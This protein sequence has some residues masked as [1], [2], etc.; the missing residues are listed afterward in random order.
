MKKTISLLLVC[1]FMTML[2]IPASGNNGDNPNLHYT[3]SL[4]ES[5]SLEDYTIYLEDFN[6]VNFNSSQDVINF[7]YTTG[8]NRNN[9][10]SGGTGVSFYTLSEEEKQLLIDYWYYACQTAA[11]SAAAKIVEMALYPDTYETDGALSNAF[12]H[13]YWTMMLCKYTSP[14][15]AIAFVT[16]HENR[17]NN[18]E[19]QKNMDLH[20]NQVSY[21][22]YVN[23]ISSSYYSDVELASIVQ[24]KINN[25]DYIY[26][27]Y[28]YQY[29]KQINH[30]LKTGIK[31]YIYDVGDFYA[32]SNS[33][34]PYDVPDTIINYILPGG[35]GIIVNS[36]SNLKE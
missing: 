7:I 1:I 27:I 22:Y 15:F 17:D 18:P 25:G 3:T 6:G 31:K 11:A 8:E 32:Y 28:Q 16:A 30:F 14:S 2:A 23:V 24:S 19:L 5:F 35:D 34:I 29:L 26:I 10:R 33:T 20:N 12:E 21:N 4:G 36:L 9:A 13:A